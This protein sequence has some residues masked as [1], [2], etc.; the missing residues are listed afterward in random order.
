MPSLIFGEK[1]QTCQY[2]LARLRVTES[3][4]E[5]LL[6][7]TLDKT[8]DFKS[9]DN[10]ICKK[11]GQKLHALAR[12]SSYM[13]VEKLRIMM[14]TFVMSQFSYCTLVWMFHDRLVH[15]KV[16]KI[17]ERALR[18]AYKDSCPSFEVL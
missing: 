11:A 5:K 4:E 3:V 15:K 1:I 9:H 2:I 16:I 6:G 7:V 18:I 14:N 12:I 10:V 17:H 8:L 13:N